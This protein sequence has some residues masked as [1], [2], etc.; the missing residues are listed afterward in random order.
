M[1]LIELSYKLTKI[2]IRQRSRSCGSVRASKS[3]LGLNLEPT[4]PVVSWATCCVI[5]AFSSSVRNFAVDGESGIMKKAVMPK[6]TV[7]HPS[8]TNIILQ[9][10]N[11][12]LVTC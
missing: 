11:V 12:S 2:V 10:W 8:T 6:T 1:K 4:A 3:C 9:L 7:T 5:I